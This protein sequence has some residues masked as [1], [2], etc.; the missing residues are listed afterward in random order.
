MTMLE[1]SDV[2]FFFRNGY[3]LVRQVYDPK[4]VEIARE[5]FLKAFRE[6]VWKNSK[7]D[8]SEI[9]NDIYR[10]YPGLLDIVINEQY[11]AA[12]KSLLGDEIVWLPECAV[13]YNRFTNWHRD[14]TE[15]EL[16]GVKSHKNPDQFLLQCATYFQS[17][18]DRGGGLTVIPGSHLSEDRF[19]SF[20]KKDLFHRTINKAKKMMRMSLFD[21][22]D[23]SGLAV[24]IPTEPGDLLIFD[25]RLCHKS[26]GNGSK[27]ARTEKFAIFNTFGNANEFTRDYLS[28]IKKRPEPSY[29]FMQN[30]LLPQN[31]YKKAMRLDI[32]IWN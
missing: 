23:H 21:Q 11:T 18:A 1:K 17:N 3:L 12:L 25:V 7:Y 14:T 28:F 22:L 31:V 5:L 19:L 30:T 20:Y 13:H 29:R 10:I 2:D 15:Q 16:K 32:K 6:G 27:T 26:S 8:S 24:D 9:I 4:D